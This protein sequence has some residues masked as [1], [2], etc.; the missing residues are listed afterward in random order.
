MNDL[1]RQQEAQRER[2]RLIDS[3][4]HPPRQYPI[5]GYGFELGTAEEARKESFGRM[6]QLIF[7][8]HFRAYSFIFIITCIQILLFF[9]TVGYD[10]NSD[11][12]LKPTVN[13]L[14]TFGA[15]N[16]ERMIEDYELWRWVTPMFLHADLMHLTFN[17]I[18]QVILGFRLEPTVGPWITIVIYVGSAIGGVLFSCLVSPDTLSVGASTAI[19][20]LISSMIAWIIFNWS[21]LENDMYRTVTIIWLIVIL[22]FSLLMGFVSHI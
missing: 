11:D 14:D 15:K 5:L 9:V 18:M 3:Q 4:Q 10:Y 17:L 16:P 20:G 21:S 13:S 1:R 19:F 8:P 7:C 6:L 12:F 22:V 2:Q